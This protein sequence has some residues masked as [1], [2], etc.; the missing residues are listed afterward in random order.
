MNL[1][2]HPAPIVQQRLDGQ[3]PSGLNGFAL[4]NR[5][6][7]F[8]VVPSSKAGQCRS[9]A[10]VPLQN[11]PYYYERPCPFPWYRAGQGKL[12]WVGPIW[13]YHCVL[14]VEQVSACN[15]A[16]SR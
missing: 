8:L 6:L 3:Q 12:E 1:S 9:F 15:V 7:P 4:L 11:L 2:I 10:P 13:G 16:W 14:H 5:I